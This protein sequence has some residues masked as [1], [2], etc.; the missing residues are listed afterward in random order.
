MATVM[1]RC[2]RTDRAVST[3]IETERPDFERLPEVQA[4]L[5]CPICGEVHVW[6]RSNAWLAEATLVPGDNKGN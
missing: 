1:I 2:P 4:R 3:E 6:T 5:Q